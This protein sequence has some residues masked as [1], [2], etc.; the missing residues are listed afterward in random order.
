MTVI[1][2]S[3]PYSYS[4]LEKAA[5]LT[6]EKEPFTYV[7][8]GAGAEVTLR[9]NEEAFERWAIVPRV[10]KDVSSRNL[11][12]NLLGT[13]LPSSFMLAPIGNQGIL[14]D[15]G[16]LASAKAAAAFGVPF[17]AS[18]VSTFSLEEIAAANGDGSR[19]F[20]LYWSSDFEVTASMVQRAE[21]AGYSAIVVTVDMPV[22]GHRERD[23]NYQY[24]PL[25]LGKGAANFLQDPVFQSRLSKSPVEER[26]VALAELLSVF[27]EP[28][29]TWDKVQELRKITSLPIL[30]KGILHADDAK[31]AVDLAF[32]GI[33]VS[34]HGGRQL[35][36]CF[37]SLDA[38]PAI[39][40]TVKGRIP[41]LFDSGIRR[42]ADAVKALSLGADAVLL[43]RP[44]VYGLA[45]GGENG[46]KHVIEQFIK[47][48]D[49]AIALTGLTKAS[50][51]NRSILRKVN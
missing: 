43:G 26:D 22:V 35:D 24:F 21:T 15:E 29:L 36:G 8:S 46:V 2:R 20:Q 47:D 14:H 4:H 3:L 18:T 49:S 10:L 12:A 11:S 23:L 13:H 41:V 38:L 50:D 45:A 1:E 6:L 28:A 51:A 27:F 40:D 48:F 32:D 37:S 44:Y 16:E 34:N 39:A 19:W 30:I 5:E 9:A 7:Q 42:G 17:I 25:A 33:V 31:I